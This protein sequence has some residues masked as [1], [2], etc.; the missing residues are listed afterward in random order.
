[1]KFSVCSRSKFVHGFAERF[2]IVGQIRKVILLNQNNCVEC[3]N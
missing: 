1:M 2:K 3:S